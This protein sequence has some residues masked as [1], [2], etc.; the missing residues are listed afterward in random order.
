MEQNEQ[1]VRELQGINE[2]LE[3]MDKALRGDMSHPGLVAR[4]EMIEK[5]IEK[6]P[7]ILARTV[8]IVSLVVTILLGIFA[9]IIKA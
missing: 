7:K 2:K 5:E 4:V 3:K 1:I 6:G 9:L 8:G